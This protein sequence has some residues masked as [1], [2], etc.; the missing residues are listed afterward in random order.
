M[1][2][3]HWFSNFQ[4]THSSFWSRKSEPSALD[5][6]IHH[7]A[8]DLNANTFQKQI[9]SVLATLNLMIQTFVNSSKNSHQRDI[10]LYGVQQ[11]MKPKTSIEVSC[12]GKYFHLNIPIH[13]SFTLHRT[14]VILQW[15]SL[16]RICCC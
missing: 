2:C 13:I 10:T 3:H 8:Q 9:L 6:S 11:R 5:L 7:L 12:K 4:F 14:S 16:V 1:S 15:T